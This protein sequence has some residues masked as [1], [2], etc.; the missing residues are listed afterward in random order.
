MINLKKTYN[1]NQRKIVLSLILA[2]FS[3]VGN[4]ADHADGNAGGHL[5]VL[6]VEGK[7]LKDVQISKFNV[8]ISKFNVNKSKL[9]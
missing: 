5:P 9:K 6:H 2:M 4:A 8:Q 7:D 3:M 1:M